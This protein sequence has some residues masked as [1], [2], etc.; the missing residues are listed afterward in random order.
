MVSIASVLVAV[1]AVLYARKLDDK[2][3][4][5]V[6][7][8][9]RS[10]TAA[11]GSAAA[12]ASTAALD[13]ERRHAELTPRFLVSLGQANPGVETKRLYVY[14][15]GPP[16]LERLDELTVTI[17]DDHPWRGQ[18]RQLAGGPT[19][20]QVARQIWGP[21]RFTPG[22]GPGADAVRGI[23]GADPT[24]RITPTRGMPVGEGLQFSL[25][26]T[27][28]PPWSQQPPEDWRRERGPV[29][30]LQLE[31]RRDG[32][33]PWTLVG[34]VSTGAAAGVPSGVVEIP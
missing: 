33:D 18:G 23:P 19:P 1:V 5:A 14:L 26:P 13:R 25:E 22:T 29:V 16:E 2:A 11:E 6:A 7:A 20:E 4:K 28:P 30:R 8:A 17:R 9:E 31:C 3:A 32:W 24:G 10:A 34:E 21:Y 27:L 15:I 12:A